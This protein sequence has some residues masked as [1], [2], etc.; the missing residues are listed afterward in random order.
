MDDSGQLAAQESKTVK[1]PYFAGAYKR[2]KTGL[3]V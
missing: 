1:T 2:V 3:L